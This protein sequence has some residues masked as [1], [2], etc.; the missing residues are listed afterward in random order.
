MSPELA[1]ERGLEHGEYATIISA[2]TA[3]EARVMVTDRVRPLTVGGRTIHQV[4]MPYHWGQRGL[5]TG[6]SV[7]DLFSLALD[8]NVHIQESKAGT[9]DVRP[10][11]RPRGTALLELVDEYRRRAGVAGRGSQGQAD[12]PQVAVSRE[13]GPGHLRR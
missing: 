10:G 2:R 11:R 5:V 12:D 3:I 4:G 13:V 6:D 1:A 7:N 8:P 9:C